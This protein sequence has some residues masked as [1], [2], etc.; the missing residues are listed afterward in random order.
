MFHGIEGRIE[1][2]LHKVGDHDENSGQDDPETSKKVKS[3]DSDTTETPFTDDIEFMDDLFNE[4][5]FAQD[6]VGF[7]AIAG[8]SVT[9]DAAWEELNSLIR[10]TARN[11]ATLPEEIPNPEKSTF[12]QAKGRL[13]INLPNA[14][15]TITQF[16]SPAFK[17]KGLF[18]HLPAWDAFMLSNDL[19]ARISS[20]PQAGTLKTTYEEDWK[21]PSR[22]QVFDANQRLINTPIAWMAPEDPPPGFKKRKSSRLN[23]QADI[24][25]DIARDCAT[26][27]SLFNVISRF[28]D[29][30]VKVPKLYYTTGK[31]VD[32][33]TIDQ[34]FG[35]I[36]DRLK[37][38]VQDFEYLKQTPN[39]QTDLAKKE[40]IGEHFLGFY[41]LWIDSDN[42]RHLDRQKDY[43]AP[44][45][46]QLQKAV[47]VVQSKL[48]KPRRVSDS[49]SVDLKS[50]HLVNYPEWTTLTQLAWKKVKDAIGQ[51]RIKS[52]SVIMLSLSATTV[53]EPFEWDHQE[54]PKGTKH[55]AEVSAYRT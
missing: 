50:Q 6:A 38:K 44:N 25:T 55:R 36:K 54:K 35:N 8:A 49:D 5:I 32:E 48:N 27:C 1:G 16:E 22:I 31:G 39:P 29:P 17:D 24:W 11:L 28:N 2:L 15:K 43:A 10:I 14:K 46:E 51:K 47:D 19:K 53:S 3:E 18:I 4:M 45:P 9:D 21:N 20:E 26:N 40:L 33:K 42:W 52:Q 7:A 23:R 41:Q 30:D 13:A 34:A 12:K 37:M